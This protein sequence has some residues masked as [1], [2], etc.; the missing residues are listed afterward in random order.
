MMDTKTVL[1]TKAEYE[2]FSKFD[3]REFVELPLTAWAR[4]YVD[5]LPDRESFLMRN[6]LTIT[7]DVD[8][9]GNHLYKAHFEPV[10]R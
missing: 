4:D 1:I 3:F 5:G 6:N 7:H 2:T 10:M 9:D 8:E